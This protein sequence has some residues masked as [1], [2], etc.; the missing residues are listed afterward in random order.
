M[1]KS[2]ADQLMAV[3]YHGLACIH[4]HTHTDTDAKLCAVASAPQNLEALCRK[5]LKKVR[6]VAGCVF[7]TICP[8][9]RTVRNVKSFA[10]SVARWYPPSVSDSRTRRHNVATKHRGCLSHPPT[11]S[12]YVIYLFSEQSLK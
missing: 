3:V 2:L 1:A 8:A 11:G 5:W 10:S 7:G 4:P 6:A 9:I 12:F